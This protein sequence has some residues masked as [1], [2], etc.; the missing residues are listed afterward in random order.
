MLQGSMSARKNDVRRFILMLI[1]MER[2]AN[3]A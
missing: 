2:V 3:A 1:T